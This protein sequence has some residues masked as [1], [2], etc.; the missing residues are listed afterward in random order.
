MMSGG[1]LADYYEKK[2]FEQDPIWPEFDQK[3]VGKLI[4]MAV[5]GGRQTRQISNL[6][7]VE[8]MVEIQ[9]VLNSVIAWD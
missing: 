7:F 5:S 8:S 9:A 2:I 3:G 6:E 1:F 4:E